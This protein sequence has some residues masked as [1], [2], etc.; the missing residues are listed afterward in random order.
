MEARTL[1]QRA[2][3]TKATKALYGWQNPTVNQ[4]DC[5]KS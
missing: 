4:V 1:G 2:Y 3:D 5:E